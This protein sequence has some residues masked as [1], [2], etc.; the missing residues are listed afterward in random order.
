V[1]CCICSLRGVRDRGESFM[2][3]I[4]SPF[5][6]TFITAPILVYIL[7]FITTK[8]LTKNHR[9]SVRRALDY[10]T[11][12]FIL[13]VHF[14][15]L[16][17]WERSFLSVIFIFMLIC[18]IIFVIINWKLKGEIVLSRFFKGYWRFCFLLFF[19]AYILLTI[20]GLTQRV[21]SHL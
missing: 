19:L 9:K 14:I 11:I 7:V 20:Y 18:A 6:A 3:S 21:S 17:I 2:L 1:K 16:T 12:F 15:A 8:L 5:I 13:S 10:S 4:L